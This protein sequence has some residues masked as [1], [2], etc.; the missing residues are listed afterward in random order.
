MHTYVRLNGWGIR[1]VPKGDFEACWDEEERNLNLKLH[2]GRFARI[3]VDGAGY[4]KW[5]DSG[6]TKSLGEVAG[7][8]PGE[9][10]PYWR[11][12]TSLYRFVWP[13]GYRIS[14]LASNAPTIAVDL[15]GQNGEC[16]F[17]QSPRTMPPLEQMAGQG[18]SILEKDVAARTVLLGYVMERV[19]WRQRHAVVT[20]GSRDLVVSGQGPADCFAGIERAMH[21]VGASLE[22][23]SDWEVSKCA[24]TFLS[25]GL[26]DPVLAD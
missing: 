1:V 16:V 9:A 14:C 21:D 13:A 24:G 8:S 22:M 26:R 23:T 3:Q 11:A 15:F 5:L 2:D 12:E 7:I 4:R 25:T 6:T 18:Q 10:A 17:I 19:A 20:V